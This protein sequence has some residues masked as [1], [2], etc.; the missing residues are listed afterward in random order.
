MIEQVE[1]D[2]LIC[3]VEGQQIGLALNKVHSVVLAVETMPLPNAPHHFLGAINVHGEITC[4]I[5][6]RKLL[7]L[8]AKE[9]DINDQFI[10]CNIH[11]KQVALWVDC[12]KNI[13]QVKTDEFIPA[14]QVLPDIKALQYVLKE[15]DQMI[16]VYDLE[17]L[18]PSNSLTFPGNQL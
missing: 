3:T 1:M 4:V 6:M 17:K 7:G 11:Q 2:I 8:K 16:L 14:E 18:I 13:K 5:D 12:V 10:L 9:L 15:N